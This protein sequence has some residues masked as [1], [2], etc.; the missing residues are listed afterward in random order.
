METKEMFTLRT[1]RER[2]GLNQKEAAVQLGISEDTLSNYERGKS[3]PD[4]PMIQKIEE[5]YKI[6]YD[7]LIFLAK[8]YG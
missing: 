3:Y 5:L 1:A 8:Q 7:Q 4:V 2:I 6:K